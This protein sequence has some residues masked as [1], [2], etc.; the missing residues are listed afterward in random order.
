MMTKLR[1]LRG[2]TAVSSGAATPSTSQP[3]TIAAPS[4]SC[5][6]MARRI[7]ATP[8][9]ASLRRGPGRGMH[10]ARRDGVKAEAH[11]RYRHGEGAQQRTGRRRI[12][13]AYGLQQ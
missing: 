11:D 12:E 10:Q 7:T 2:S 13:A 9:R 6:V 8:Q 5:Q 3:T 1:V 4:A